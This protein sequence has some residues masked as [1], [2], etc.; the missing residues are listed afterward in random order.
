MPF[1]FTIPRANFPFADLIEDL[2]QK[3]HICREE[4][5][6]WRH[7]QI[8]LFLPWFVEE[9]LESRWQGREA[10]RPASSIDEAEA[11]CDYVI[12]MSMQSPTSEALRTAPVIERWCALR[13]VFEEA[14]YPCL[15]GYVSGHP[16]LR[17][18]ARVRTS[19]LIRI[20]PQEGWARTWSR[21][22]R[23]GKRDAAM[24]QELER[25]RRLRPGLE[26]DWDIMGSTVRQ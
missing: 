3:I 2:E 10:D 12:D 21:H 26:I 17:E 1:P 4:N 24:F 11:F 23:L 9:F 18:G 6:T 20:E 16:I 14:T 5:G 25:D 22:Y 7:V 19:A 15:I 8:S 13:E